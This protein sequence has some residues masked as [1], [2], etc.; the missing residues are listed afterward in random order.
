MTHL[1]RSAHAPQV[2]ARIAK[3]I[4]QSAAARGG[5]PD[6]IAAGALFDQRVL[7]D[8][9]AAIP[10]AQ[11]EILWEVAA[12]ACGD[13]DFGLHAAETLRPGMFDV[14]DYAA[15]TAPNLK[16]ALNRLVRYNR[17]VHDLAVFTATDTPEGVRI[18]HRFSR[19]GQ[20][21]CRHASECT[22]ASILVAARQMTGTA[23]TALEVAFAH[24]NPPAVVEHE[25]IFGV[26]PT[27]GADVSTMVLRTESV[28]RPIL[29]ADAALS[30]IVNAHAESL[31]QAKPPG[32]FQLTAEVR[33]HLEV[34][35]SDGVPRLASVAKQLHMSQR[36]LQ[37][38]LHSEGTRFTELVDRVRKDMALRY[39]GE[40]KLVLGEV[41][42]LLGFTEPSTFHR[43]FR[44]WTGVTASAM[45]RRVP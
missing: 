5:D 17:L 33:R 41:A 45:R 8:P 38:G 22:L 27:F 7:A 20:A 6:Q 32:E 4:L 3:L 28:N 44:R 43:A 36:S 29:A 11:E 42:Y 15:R 34:R 24:G 23:I 2:S 35:L 40:R 14:L 9:D 16:E 19:P 31:L 12:T 21:P 10:L 30:R 37:R 18:E 39:V 25:R 13:D 1:L 26:K